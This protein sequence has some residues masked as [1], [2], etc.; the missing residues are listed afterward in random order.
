MSKRNWRCI[1]VNWIEGQTTQKFFA[2]HGD[3]MYRR[4]YIW[5][6]W[7]RTQALKK[8]HQ[9][10]LLASRDQ[11][12]DGRA[13]MTSSSLCIRGKRFA[14]RTHDGISIGR[15]NGKNRSK[16]CCCCCCWRY[17]QVW[18]DS[19]QLTYDKAKRKGL[20][21]DDDTKRNATSKRCCC[22][23]SQHRIVFHALSLYSRRS[24]TNRVVWRRRHKNENATS[25][26]CCCCCCCYSHVR[27]DTLQ[28]TYDTA[29]KGLYEDDDTKRNA[30][31]KRCCCCC[32]QN[33]IVFQALYSRR[34]TQQIWRRHKN[35]NAQIQK[36][37]L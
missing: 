20:Y 10:L 9:T 6:P 2:M 23:C 24:K 21:E 33:R 13:L 22:S 12:F 35:E 14:T 15:Q 30:T 27:P 34:K 19:L 37:L 36:L 1:D 28:L 31:S 29:K 5:C 16:R 26:R 18:P 3:P 11:S 25:K 7:M 8:K 4:R 32:S 17:S